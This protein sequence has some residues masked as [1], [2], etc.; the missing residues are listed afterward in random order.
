[1]RIP[2][3][4]AFEN[5]CARG[6]DNTHMTLSLW[7]YTHGHQARPITTLAGPHFVQLIMTRLSNRMPPHPEHP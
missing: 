2:R 7:V 3:P 6:T 5:S 4:D 1:M